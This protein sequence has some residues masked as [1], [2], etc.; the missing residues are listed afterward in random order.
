MKTNYIEALFSKETVHQLYVLQLL[1]KHEEGLTVEELKGH[2][3]V[4]RRS[5]YKIIEQLKEVSEEEGYGEIYFSKGAYFYKGNKVMYF[6][7]RSQLIEEEPMLLLAK[8]F[9]TKNVISLSSFCESVYISES[10]LKRY[11]QR[12]NGLVRSFGIQIR[13]IK[14]NIE[15]FGQET[16]IRYCLSSFLWRIYNGVGWPFEGVEQEKAYKTA[17]AI[18]Y[19]E[20]GIADGKKQ[21]TAYALATHILRASANY[22]VSEEE[23]PD[24]YKELIEDNP[25]FSEFSD[26]IKANFQLK[27]IEIEYIFLRLYTLAESYNYFDAAEKTMDVLEKYAPKSYKSVKDFLYFVKRIHPEF[28][29]S[30]PKYRAFLNMVLAGRIFVDIF[31]DAYFNYANVTPYYYAERDYSHLLPTLEKVVQKSEP[32]LSHATVKSLTLRYG[33]AYTMEFS[34]L[35]FE[36]HLSLLLDTA[37]PMYIDEMVRDRIHDVLHTRFNFSWSEHNNAQPDLLI[38][39]GEIENKDPN[40]PIVYIN[41]EVLKKDENALIEACEQIVF[42]KNLENKI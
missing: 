8:V 18:L 28:H 13:I 36:P 10:T 38:A 24:Y 34:P 25:H 40:V 3:S 6:K 22:K 21:Q 17:C 20:K 7:L 2:I 16:V 29:V 12:I 33:Q 14:N 30:L 11:L 42:Q 4:E 32:S 31:G 15:L 39:T 27:T 1:Y 23:L 37:T 19:T 35:D 41:I 5:V 26:K 9:L